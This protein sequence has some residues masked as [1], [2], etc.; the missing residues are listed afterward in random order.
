MSK[1][2]TGSP[3]RNWRLAFVMPNL[4]MRQSFDFGDVAIVNGD[5]DILQEI[6]NASTAAKALLSGF[7]G[8]LV[9]GRR[10]AALI[11]RNPDGVAD[12]WSAMV[13]ARNAVAVAS[14]CY[15]WVQSI[16]L[17]NAFAVRYTDHFDFYPRWPTKDGKSLVYQGPAVNLLSTNVHEFRGTTHP[18]LSVSNF[19]QPAFDDDL[20]SSTMGAWRRIHVRGKPSRGDRRLF[21]ALS[22]AYEACRVPQ[23]MD[24]PLYDHGKHCSLWVSA[25]ETLAHPGTWVGFQQVVDL[26]G[27]RNLADTNLSRK[28]RMKVSM[29]GG[30]PKFQ[31]LNVAQRLYTRLYAARNKFLHGNKISFRDFVPDGLKAGVRLLDTAPLVFH[32][33]LEASMSLHPLVPPRNSSDEIRRILRYKALEESFLRALGP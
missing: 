4:V 19:S 17:P 2:S 15:G 23:A 20:L 22:V 25:F 3:N 28:V 7:A 21:R 32:A 27:K 12:L 9:G 33:A 5:E 1:R 31:A 18:Y 6:E 8:S 13:D 24:N 26:V 30:K 29:R 14:A 16:G 11:Y 10:P